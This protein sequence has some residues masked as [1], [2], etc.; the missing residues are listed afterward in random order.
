MPYG[1]VARFTAHDESAAQ[2]FDALAA[3][4]LDKVR[5]HEPATL[6]YVNHAPEGEPAVRI[7]YE[8]YTDRDAF[9]AHE[10]QPYVREFLCEREQ[11][12]RDTEVTFLEEVAGKRPG[13]EDQ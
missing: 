9:E 5:V 4:V 7:F 3:S 13:Q 12:L 8:L 6:V 11:Y 2:R 1:L 10:R